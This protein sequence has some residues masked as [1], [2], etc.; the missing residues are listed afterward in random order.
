MSNTSLRYTRRRRS[1]SRTTPVPS[2]GKVDE[3]IRDAHL[4]E[5]VEGDMRRKVMAVQWTI[6]PCTPAVLN[7]LALVVEV[8]AEVEG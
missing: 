8:W 4:V 6:N 5:N 3:I 2:C 1:Q 7:L